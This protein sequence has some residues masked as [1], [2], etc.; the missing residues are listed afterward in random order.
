MM[1]ISELGKGGK[2]AFYT[3]FALR[4]LAGIVIYGNGDK[5]VTIMRFSSALPN[6]VWLLVFNLGFRANLEKLETGIGSLYWSF[7]EA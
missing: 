4:T 3:R 6:L 1:P 7:A 5:T 2:H